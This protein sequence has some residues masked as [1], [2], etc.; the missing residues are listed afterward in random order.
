MN[1]VAIDALVAFLSLRTRTIVQKNISQCSSEKYVSLPGM[2]KQ[3]YRNEGRTRICETRRE[4]LAT[5]NVYNC[6]FCYYR[7]PGSGSSIEHLFDCKWV[8]LSLMVKCLSWSLQQIRVNMK[9]FVRNRRWRVLLYV[10]C[11]WIDISRSN[12]IVQFSPM[13]F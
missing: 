12:A 1:G 4:K 2:Q 3:D 8:Q 10:L 6:N 13:L 11:L 7:H 5:I 9:R